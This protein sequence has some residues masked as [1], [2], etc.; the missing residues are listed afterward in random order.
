ME[1]DEIKNNIL[2]DETQ[3]KR[4]KPIFKLLS[5]LL[6][7]IVLLGLIYILTLYFPQPFFKNKI[8]YNKI[9]LYS[10][11]QIPEK[12]AIKI[13]KSAE[14]NIKKS[15]IYKK[16]T[17]HNIY[18]ANNKLRWLYFSNKNNNAGGLNYVIFNHSIFLRK[19][20]VLNNRLFNSK[21]EKVKGDRTLDYFIAHEI[22]HT[23]EFQSMKFYK[24]PL[25]TNWVIEGYAEYIAHGSQNYES[26]LDYYLNVPENERAKYY[27]RVRTMVTY[28]LEV[29]KVQISDLWDMVDDYDDVL[30]DAIPNDSPAIEE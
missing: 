16:D 17:I 24:Y 20:D 25:N 11:E 2:L 3:L 29:D 14:E 15:K 4:V 13:L 19:A 30:N 8:T 28:L 18:F 22:T 26:S 12:E 21:G 6:L 10:D 5:R 23:L 1:K 9:S 7:V 27:T